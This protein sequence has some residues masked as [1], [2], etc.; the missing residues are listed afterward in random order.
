MTAAEIAEGL[1]R[2]GIVHET[3]LPYSPYQN[4]KQESFWGPVEGRLIAMLE[5][6]PDLTLAM[7]NEATQAW[8]E[9]DYNRKLHSEIGEAP[10][11]RFLKGPEVTRPSPDS[12]ALRLAF[13]RTEQ[14]TQRKSDGTV[15]IA[16][17]RFEVPNRYRHL[18]GA[19]VRF[20]SWDLTTVH[21]VDSRTGTV[22]CRL[23]PQDKT[24]NASGLR[25]PL[26]KVTAE[27]A[28]AKSSTGMAPLLAQLLARQ[29]AAGLPPP[30]L[31]KDEG[32]DT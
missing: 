19:E 1:A 21:L 27:P 15:V 6:V 26:D 24:K 10:I 14:R 20:A 12:A 28:S 3:T 17:R 16:G 31:P 7:L 22:L 8:V 5:D 29:A 4:A 2:L 32:D 13:T 11:T 30:Y 25:R 23:Y 18:R 9:F